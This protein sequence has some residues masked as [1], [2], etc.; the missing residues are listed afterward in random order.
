MK[1]EQVIDLYFMEA[2][3]KLID[4]AAFLDR[5]DR[6]PRNGRFSHGGLSPGSARNCPTASQIGPNAFC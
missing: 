2:R 1:R 6:A 4:L 5:V 3:A